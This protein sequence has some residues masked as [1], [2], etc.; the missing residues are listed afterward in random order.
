[1]RLHGFSR[2]LTVALA[3][4][5]LTG[6]VWAA[7][8]DQNDV[9]FNAGLDRS[10]HDSCVSAA[11]EHGAPA[12]AAERYCTCVVRELDKLS[13]AQRKALTPSSPKVTAAARLCQ[14]KATAH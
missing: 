13:V 10:L 3:V 8:S 5:A 6:P 9:A 1:M 7:T 12:D 11:T 2:V 14:A 4:A